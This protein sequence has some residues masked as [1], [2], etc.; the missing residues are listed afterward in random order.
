MKNLELLYLTR[1]S[2]EQCQNT[3]SKVESFKQS[4]ELK[5]Y[6]NITKILKAFI[7]KAT[8]NPFKYTYYSGL[9]AKAR[10]NREIWQIC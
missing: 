4:N 2:I 6:V 3:I 10:K 1:E 5:K 9:L 7:P 8:L